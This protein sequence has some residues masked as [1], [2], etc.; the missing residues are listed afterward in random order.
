MRIKTIHISDLDKNYSKKYQYS[1]SKYAIQNYDEK[2][3]KFMNRY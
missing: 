2:F 3:S 1:I